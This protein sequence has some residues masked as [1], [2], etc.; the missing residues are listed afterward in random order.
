V[1][2][3]L[4]A[5]SLDPS[6]LGALYDE[7]AG[8]LLAV[9]WRLTGS[10]ADAEDVVHDVFVGLPE[11]LRSY[12]ER[13]QL[14]AWLSRLTARTALMRLRASQRRREA[15]LDE[16]SA[17]EG[18]ERAEQRVELATLEQQIL[19]LPEPLRVVFV[20]REIEGYSHDEIAAMLAISA[21]ASRVRFSRALEQ[22]RRQLRLDAPMSSR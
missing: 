12:E 3:P 5:R 10:R 21:G 2:R 20:L 9:A 7:F 22:L 18:S 11:A 13:G 17:M 8:R 1:P 14:G 4:P 16:A 6:N 15:P 19:A